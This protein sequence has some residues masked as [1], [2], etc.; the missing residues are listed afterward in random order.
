MVVISLADLARMSWREII[1]LRNELQAYTKQYS[2]I[3]VVELEN[4]DK[5]IREK[6]LKNDFISSFL[7]VQ[8]KIREASLMQNKKKFSL[9]SKSSSTSQVCGILVHHF[10]LLKHVI[11]L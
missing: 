6:E 4:R 8:A 5:Y 10:M 1:N 7:A 9:Q 11:L 2:D 3:L